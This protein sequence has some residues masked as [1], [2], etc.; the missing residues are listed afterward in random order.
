MRILKDQIFLNSPFFDGMNDHHAV[1]LILKMA[2][3]RESVRVVVQNFANSNQALPSTIGPDGRRVDSF[4]YALPMSYDRLR[5]QMFRFNDGQ[6][7]YDAI[8]QMAERA[9]KVCYFD[10]YGTFH[11]ESLADDN[12][13]FGTSNTVS[14]RA[15]YSVNPCNFPDKQIAFKQASQQRDI[16]SVVNDIHIITS[17]PDSALAI[18]H[19]TNYKS[20]T[21]TNSSGFLGYKKTLLQQDGI[22][23]SVAAA[24]RVADTYARIMYKPPVVW[25]IESYGRH[26]RALDVIDLDGQPFRIMNLTNEIDGSQNRWWQTIEGEWFIPGP[27]INWNPTN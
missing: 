17:T 16:D 10:P 12:T 19:D 23:G 18:A 26:L 5:Q 24:K 21:D 1:N 22:F 15:F 9:G 6:K 27:P 3:F 7:Y 13:I 20:I 14:P 25:R 11:Y 8:I 4:H 2:Q